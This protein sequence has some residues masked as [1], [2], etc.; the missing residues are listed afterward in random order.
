MIALS[1]AGVMRLNANVSRTNL[2]RHFWCNE[3]QRWV[4]IAGDLL[5][6]GNATSARQAFEAASAYLQLAM[7]RA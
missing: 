2:M 4:D 7:G 1:Y 3:W 5:R 6:Q